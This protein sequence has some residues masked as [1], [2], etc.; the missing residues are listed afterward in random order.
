MTQSKLNSS[1]APKNEPETSPKQIQKYFE[2]SYFKRTVAFAPVAI[3][4]SD[5]KTGSSK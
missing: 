1:L 2:K 4:I 5:A 3:R